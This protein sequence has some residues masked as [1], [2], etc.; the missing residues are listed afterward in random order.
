MIFT[1]NLVTRL[2][3]QYSHLRTWISELDERLSLRYGDR[4]DNIKQQFNGANNWYKKTKSDAQS[5]NTI[6]LEQRQKKTMDQFAKGGAATARKEGVVK[7]GLK[8]LW[9]TITNK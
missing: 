7:Q 5:S 2:Q 1:V 8:D 4:Y 9:R 6:P 3:A